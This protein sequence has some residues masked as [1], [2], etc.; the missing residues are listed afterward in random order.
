MRL[1]SYKLRHGSILH[2]NFFKTYSD[3]QKGFH[4]HQIDQVKQKPD[5]FILEHYSCENEDGKEFEIKLSSEKTEINANKKVIIEAIQIPLDSCLQVQ[6]KKKPSQSVFP[7]MMK[8]VI[9]FFTGPK[10]LNSENK[11]DISLYQYLLHKIGFRNELIEQAEDIFNEEVDIIK[12]LKSLHEIEKLKLILFDEDQY[13]LFDSITKPY[14]PL[15]VKNKDL[16]LNKMTSMLE[17]LKGK[18]SDENIKIQAYQR[19]LK[20]SEKFEGMDKKIIDLIKKMSQK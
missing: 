20:R 9:E 2:L 13:I 5:S 15:T 8:S 10:I 14:S 18:K 12:I 19:I 11:I 4:Q 17:S 6:R 7:M 3:N 16:V 1:R